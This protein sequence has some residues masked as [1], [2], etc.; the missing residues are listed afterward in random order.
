M[1]SINSVFENRRVNE[2]FDLI[3]LKKESAANRTM[4]KKRLRSKAKVTFTAGG[5]EVPNNLRALFVAVPQTFWT[6]PH[7]LEATN[8][9]LT[10][11]KRTS[12]PGMHRADQGYTVTARNSV[13][14][15]NVVLISKPDTKIN[16]TRNPGLQNFMNVQGFNTIASTVYGKDDFAMLINCI[17][18]TSSTTTSLANVILKQKNGSNIIKH[19]PELTQFIEPKS[20]Y[21]VVYALQDILSGQDLLVEHYEADKIPFGTEEYILCEQACYLAYEQALLL[22]P[23]LKRVCYRCFETLTNHFDSL[24]QECAYLEGHALVCEPH[25]N[26]FYLPQ[27][28]A[29]TLDDLCELQIIRE[30][31]R[32]TKK[33]KIEE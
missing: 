24:E 28:D 13:Q 3:N 31:K 14:Q 6:S 17:G 18:A 9:H 4:A 27:I 22:P 10:L 16:E 2:N 5:R 30:I 15:G 11:T 32:K 29:L 12:G 26:Q 20:T 1:V 21:V 8:F 23:L 19:H 25:M 33:L 7:Y